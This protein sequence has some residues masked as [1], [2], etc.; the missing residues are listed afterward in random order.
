MKVKK[1]GRQHQQN[2]VDKKRIAQRK[3]SGFMAF[4]HGSI[5]AI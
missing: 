2:I 4:T 5:P 3:D 1:K